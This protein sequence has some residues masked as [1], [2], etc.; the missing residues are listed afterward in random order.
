MSSISTAGNL[1]AWLPRSERSINSSPSAT[2]T[3]SFG[4]PL[5][6]AGSSTFPAMP[7]RNIRSDRDDVGLPDIHTEHIVGGHHH[8]RPVFAEVDP[9]HRT[10]GHHGAERSIRSSAANHAV[11]REGQLRPER[12]SASTSGR[13]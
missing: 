11:S 8:A 7:A 12:T 10:P 3:E 13:E 6:V 2:A 4:S 1:P 5:A 9:V